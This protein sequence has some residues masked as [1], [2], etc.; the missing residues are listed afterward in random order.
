MA[1]FLSAGSRIHEPVP[2]SILLDLGLW[3]QT[4]TG[5]D[6]DVSSILPD[7]YRNLSI[8]N[9]YISIG[10]SYLDNYPTT[11]KYT[12]PST[13]VSCLT[14]SIPTFQAT[15]SSSSGFLHVL[16]TSH[17][18]WKTNS[19]ASSEINPFDITPKIR[20]YVVKDVQLID[21]G[22][23]TLANNGTYQSF[24]VTDIYSDWVNLTKKNF[25]YKITSI[26]D[27]SDSI[28]I[29]ANNSYNIEVGPRGYKEYDGTTGEIQVSNGYFY[30][31]SGGSS[32]LSYANTPSNVH[33]YLSP[34]IPPTTD[35]TI[36]DLGASGG[37][38]GNASLDV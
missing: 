30:G 9:F 4:S 37:S 13:S 6:I 34:T 3:E 20:I 17:G 21:L 26:S 23:K 33:I 12:G 11:G 29:P 7:D 8:N 16:H 24:S 19:A 35:N 32:Y 15:Y 5:V 14:S 1:M 36:I 2:S 18:Y 25:I 10:E 31:Y 27:G 38:T 22:E 28:T